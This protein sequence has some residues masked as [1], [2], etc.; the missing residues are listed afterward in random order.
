MTQ[1][2]KSLGEPQGQLVLFCFFFNNNF[3]KVPWLDAVSSEHIVYVLAQYPPTLR[4]PSKWTISVLWFK[5]L[6]LMPL[7]N[8]KKNSHRQ[9]AS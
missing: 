4:F 3:K 5:P 2:V 7:M 1:E 9:I 8:I 6:S